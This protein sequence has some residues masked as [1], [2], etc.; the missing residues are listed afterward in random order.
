MSIYQEP[1]GGRNF[2]DQESKSTSRTR[3]ISLYRYM[4]PKRTFLNC[5]PT[6]YVFAMNAPKFVRALP[7]RIL[8]RS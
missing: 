4:E 1:E 8:V 2:Y 7:V 5:N 6:V 3:H